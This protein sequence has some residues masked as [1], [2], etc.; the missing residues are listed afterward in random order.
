M[1]E[2]ML[3]LYL[4]KRAQDHK[5]SGSNM[6]PSQHTRAETPHAHST[7]LMKYVK[8]AGT[9]SHI[10]AKPYC[11]V[12]NGDIGV[13]RT[14]PANDHTININITA[15]RHYWCRVHYVPYWADDRTS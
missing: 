13:H 5:V 2:R 4:T 12:G 7:M 11:T 15:P 6:V 8:D 1:I 14:P 9:P 10:S 3:N